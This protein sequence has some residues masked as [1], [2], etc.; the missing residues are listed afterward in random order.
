[1][2]PVS[3]PIAKGGEGSLAVDGVNDFFR[4]VYSVDY[5]LW[6]TERLVMITSSM[7]WCDTDH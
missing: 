1:M 2:D 7:R 4:T 3:L 5:M 6:S